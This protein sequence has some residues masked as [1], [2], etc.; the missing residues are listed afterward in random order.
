[1]AIDGATLKINQS[2]GVGTTIR[3]QVRAA[4]AASN[5]QRKTC[6]L[7]VANPGK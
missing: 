5:V 7:L 3:W 1:V 6:E 2:G 4:D